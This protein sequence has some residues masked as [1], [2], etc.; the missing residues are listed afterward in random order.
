MFPPKTPDTLDEKSFVPSAPPLELAKTTKK[1]ITFSSAM[2]DVFTLVY[3]EKGT[4]AI[5]LSAL[6]L[7]SSINL[8][9]PTLLAKAV[10]RMIRSGKKSNS[11][12]QRKE[13]SNRSFGIMCFGVV[14]VGSFASFVRTYTLGIANRNIAM[15]LRKKLFSQSLRKERRNE[16]D[17][18]SV[19][20]VS[21]L[22]TQT[23]QIATVATNTCANLLRGLSSVIGGTFMLLR[24]SPQLT[25][26]AVSIVPVIG[27]TSMIQN[28]DKKTRVGALQNRIDETNEWAEERLHHIK[29]VRVFHRESFEE[30]SYENL[31]R[32]VRDV[33]V[34]NARSDGIFMA[35]LNL[36]LT[37]S[38]G[39]LVLFGGYLCRK[40]NVT[41]GKLTAFGM[42]TL[43]LGLGTASLISIRRKLV[44]A[45][46][47]SEHVLRVVREPEFSSSKS[48]KKTRVD[49]SGDI[50]FRNVHFHY[51]SRPDHGV[52]SSSA[53]R[54]NLNHFSFSCL[55]LE[56]Q[57]L[58]AYSN[59]SKNLTRASR[60]NTGT[61]GF[62]SFRKGWI[63]SCS[64]RCER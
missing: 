42:H 11:S 18:R 1:K 33:A 36:T 34:S 17:E 53:K 37:S 48:V 59:E 25:A 4:L 46:S 24:I 49:C 35:S 63:E 3:P 9:I 62:R 60:S 56:N 41:A 8:A 47:A 43:W 38:L 19:A 2:K 6:A 10:D 16:F 58:N 23:D 40:G 29:T 57:C 20:S 28:L 39:A 44:E 27:A 12:G 45:A 64:C 52:R 50:E 51:A 31:V 5:S 30:K 13:M 32:S 15:R 22:S 21:M 14:C 7:C 26:A 55:S 54:E 61:S